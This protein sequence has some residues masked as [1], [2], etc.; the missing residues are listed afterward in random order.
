MAVQDIGQD[1]FQKT[2]LESKTPVFVDFHAE[3][4]GPCKMT[5]PIVEQ[6]ATEVKDMTF[7]KVD[8]DQNQDL[9]TQYSVFSIPTFMIFKNGKVASQFV[10]AMGKEGF[11]QEIKKAQAA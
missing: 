7:V 11:L 3:W 5:E 6:L 4:C 1:T 9:A 2:V 10:G 8:V